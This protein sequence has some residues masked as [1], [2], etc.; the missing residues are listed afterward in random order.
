MYAILTVND[1]G[2]V[3]I[4]NDAGEV[5]ETF[6][7]EG[8][9]EHSF[10]IGN[11]INTAIAA[12]RDT[13]VVANGDRLITRKGDTFSIY[14]LTACFNPESDAS[15]ATVL[16][17]YYAGKFR[18]L[19]TYNQEEPFC[20]GSWGNNN[21]RYYES[22]DGVSWAMLIDFAV[23]EFATEFGSALLEYPSI[24]YNPNSNKY[25][26][27]SGGALYSTSDFATYTTISYDSGY[28]LGAPVTPY[29]SAFLFHSTSGLP[30]NYGYDVIKYNGSFVAY[31]LTNK[32]AE[33][34]TVQGW[35]PVMYTGDNEPY[36]YCMEVISGL[37]W[38]MTPYVF[39][40]TSFVRD[41]SLSTED[42]Y[43]SFSIMKPNEYL[44]SGS[45]RITLSLKNTLT[46][47]YD[48]YSISV[49]KPGEAPITI[50]LSGYPTD[51]CFNTEYTWSD[52]FWSE[53]VKALETTYTY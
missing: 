51:Y 15:A 21:F 22:S 31:A 14:E 3:K 26:I 34:D 42:T 8:F 28:A 40:G 20:S 36:I 16:L 38:F 24:T 50:I 33:L 6:A 2:T 32:P 30:S 47:Y 25:I 53:E 35:F 13:I 17:T 23:T 45:G 43:Y 49:L 52:E 29:G 27:E 44:I 10:S 9:V 12:N 11:Y 18:H 4:Y 1:E 41:G 37:G 5:L 46:G 19:I 48:P 7:V 39:N